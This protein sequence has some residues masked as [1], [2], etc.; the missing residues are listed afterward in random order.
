LTVIKIWIVFSSVHLNY[1]ADGL[2]TQLLPSFAK[3]SP[4]AANALLPSKET[5]S[6]RY[7]YGKITNED[8]WKQLTPFE[9]FN[10]EGTYK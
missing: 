10:K 4:Q 8:E 2:F 3:V 1:N 9:G 5:A 6:M 7:A